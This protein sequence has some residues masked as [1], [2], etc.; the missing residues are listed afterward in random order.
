[1]AVEVLDGQ[2]KG[3]GD[4]DHREVSP[5]RAIRFKPQSIFG[6]KDEEKL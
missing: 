3:P 4:N 6:S 5:K 1:M 2:A